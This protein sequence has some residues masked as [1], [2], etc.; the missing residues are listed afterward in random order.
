MRRT[1]SI[2][3]AVAALALLALPTLA[4]AGETSPYYPGSTLTV[5]LATKPRAGKVTTLIASGE[6]TSGEL[7]FGLEM[8]AK[9]AKED[10]TCMPTYEE[11]LNS[12]INEK[13]ESSIYQGES[14]EGRGPFQLPIK[15]EFN[16]VKVVICAYSIYVTDTAANDRIVFTVP[17][18]PKPKHHHRRLGR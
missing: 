12:S 4:A 15:A 18:A 6:N 9:L 11:E 14:A 10:P 3:L 7:N 1:I 16:P 8:F 17:P 2:A 5:K 13:G